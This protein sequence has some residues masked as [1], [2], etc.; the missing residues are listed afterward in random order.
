M[1]RAAVQKLVTAC[2]KLDQ[3]QERVTTPW[4]RGT[5]RQALSD[6]AHALAGATKDVKPTRALG[7][8][9]KLGV[10]AKP[11]PTMADEVRAQLV[12]QLT[13]AEVHAIVQWQGRRLGR[14]L[15]VE[16]RKRAKDES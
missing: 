15:D 6:E 9:A 5:L 8:S 4:S 11:T 13:D 14:A 16:L 3:S 12:E 7:F 1:A 2:D 10:I